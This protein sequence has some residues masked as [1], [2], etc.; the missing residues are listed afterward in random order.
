MPWDGPWVVTVPR[1]SLRARVVTPPR[2]QECVARLS[3]FM[4]AESHRE[5]VLRAEIARVHE[6]IQHQAHPEPGPGDASHPHDTACTAV[7]VPPPP[8]QS[9]IYERMAELLR[10]MEKRIPLAT[11]RIRSF[12]F[13]REMVGSCASPPSSLPC[14][15]AVPSSHAL[16]APPQESLPLDNMPFD[17][18]RTSYSPPDGAESDFPSNRRIAPSVTWKYNPPPLPDSHPFL[19]SLSRVGRITFPCALESF[20]CPIIDPILFLSAARMCTRQG[21]RDDRTRGLGQGARSN[22]FLQRAGSE[23]ENCATN[24]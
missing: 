8:A 2:V 11:N 9:G 22:N 16:V 5:A 24:R 10:D 18:E 21:V 17:T 23:F 4:T 13:A 15:T 20:L 14:G 6:L 7:I 3:A 12:Q 1:S 19:R